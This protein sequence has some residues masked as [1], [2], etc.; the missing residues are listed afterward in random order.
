MLINGGCAGSTSLSSTLTLLSRPPHS[1]TVPN[2]K[3]FR[4]RA[5]IL[6]NL[7]IHH[8]RVSLFALQYHF[9]GFAGEQLGSQ[10]LCQ[11]PRRLRSIQSQHV[12][13]QLLLF[14]FDPCRSHPAM[15]V[16]IHR[17]IPGAD[18]S[19]QRSRDI[20]NAGFAAA[21]FGRDGE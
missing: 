18:Y 5:D 2:T 19:S 4:G 6:V 15:H 7:S 20:L 16:D 9:V 12:A 14:G 10:F 8:D 11:N 17:R 1:V 3:S 13:S 21:A